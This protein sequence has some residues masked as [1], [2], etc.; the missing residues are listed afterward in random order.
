VKESLNVLDNGV[1]LTFS[2]TVV[3]GSV[4]GSELLC[5]VSFLQMG[6]E[7]LA[8]IFSPSVR[9]ENL[10]VSTKSSLAP[11]LKVLVKGEGLRLVTK[12]VNMCPASA[13]IHKGHIVTMATFSSHWCW[14]PEV[15]VRD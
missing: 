12:T 13:V 14:S 7:L 15:R 2:D 6:D 8:N 4:M 10:H 3:L 1:V 5:S 11:S 9:V